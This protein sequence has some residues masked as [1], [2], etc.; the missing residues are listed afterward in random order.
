MH[1][2][3]VAQAQGKTEYVVD[4]IPVSVKGSKDMYMTIC[5]TEEAVCITKEQAMKFF[6]LVPAKD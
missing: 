3:F 4:V 2:S 5:A 1:T 6:N